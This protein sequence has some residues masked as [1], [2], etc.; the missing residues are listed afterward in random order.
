VF[1][2]CGRWPGV[3]IVDAGPPDRR[4]VRPQGRSAGRSGPIGA[5]EAVAEDEGVHAVLDARFARGF[6]PFEEQDVVGEERRPGAPLRVRETGQDG[7][8]AL[9]DTVANRAR[10]ASGVKFAAMASRS[11]ESSDRTWSRKVSRGLRVIEA[12]SV[13]RELRARQGR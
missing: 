3:S 9:L 8:D 1:V 2:V 13:R 4:A 7:G 12:C 6:C 10:T 5:D 11:P